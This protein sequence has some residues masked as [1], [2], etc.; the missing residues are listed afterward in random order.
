MPALGSG[1][2]FGDGA[3]SDYTLKQLLSKAPKKEE[4]KGSKGILGGLANMGKSVLSALDAGRAAVVATAAEAGDLAGDLF[5]RNGGNEASFSDLRRNFNRRA[6]AGDIM[7][8]QGIGGGPGVNVLGKRLD[9]RGVAGTALDIAADPLN[10]LTL[11]SGSAANAGLR[12]AG[13]QLNRAGADDLVRAALRE[14]GSEG[15]D[16]L[17]RREGVGTLEDALG[18]RVGTLSR[19]AT[20]P[21]AMVTTPPGCGFIHRIFNDFEYSGQNSHYPCINGMKYTDGNQAIA[22]DSRR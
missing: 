12:S 21:V 17:L 15:V 19:K 6:T 2:D 7:E 5:N 13:L 3:E 18:S 4:K 1:L 10:S 14:G 22:G 16:A 9:L 8:Q 20:D 11:G